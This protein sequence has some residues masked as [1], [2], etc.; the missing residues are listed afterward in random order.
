[1]HYLF[2]LFFI[3]LS[4]CTSTNVQSNSRHPSSTEAVECA[5]PGTHAFNGR[6]LLALNNILYAYL[7]RL[8]AR[9]NASTK[10]TQILKL[11]EISEEIKY[12]K[13]EAIW[14]PDRISDVLEVQTK[15]ILS[16]LKQDSSRDSKTLENIKYLEN[17]YEPN[18]RKP[19]YWCPEKYG[20]ESLSNDL[21]NGENR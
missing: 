1:M 9:P 12:P 16:I 17:L 10:D 3:F 19:Q 11:R 6:R 18:I 2:M 8:E 21:T 13:V 20:N 4:A 15:A 14:H 7:E 5:Y